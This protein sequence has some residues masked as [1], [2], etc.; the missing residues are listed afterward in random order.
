MSSLLTGLRLG[1]RDR[2]KHCL[3]YLEAPF[4]L[5]AIAC[6]RVLV[7]IDLSPT[8]ALNLIFII[9]CGVLRY[10]GNLIFYVVSS[11]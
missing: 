11:R 7:L 1:D 4:Y 8:D 5:W 3:S 2:L 9:L 10:L 6:R